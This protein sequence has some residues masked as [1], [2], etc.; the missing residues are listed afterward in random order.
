MILIFLSLV[1][2]EITKCSKYFSLLGKSYK[3]SDGNAKNKFYLLTF[4]VL[5]LK[6]DIFDICNFKNSCFNSSAI[7]VFVKN[8]SSLLNKYYKECCVLKTRCDKLF[9]PLICRC[10]TKRSN[11]VF[12]DKNFNEK[13]AKEPVWM[14]NQYHKGSNI[15]HFSLKMIPTGIIFDTSEKFE[16]PKNLKSIYW[17]DYK[18]KNFTPWELNIYNIAL[19][20]RQ[21][22]ITKNIFHH[23]K[24][25]YCF[26]SS[27]TSQNIQRFAYKPEQL[28]EFQKNAEQKFGIVN[29]VYKSKSRNKL[30]P[31]KAV[32]I[33]RSEG[34]GHRKIIGYEIIQKI[35]SRNNISLVQKE[36]SSFNS[37]LSQAKIFN[38]YGLIIAPQTAQLTNILFAQKKT[39]VLIIGSFFYEECYNNLANLCGLR[40][41]FSRGHASSGKNFDKPS[42][43]SSKRFFPKDCFKT[44]RQSLMFDTI[45]NQSIIENDLNTVLKLLK[46]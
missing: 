14:I 18:T 33:T 19:S 40:P 24:E 16:I 10:A 20:S 35:L 12:M 46:E 3:A 41:V 44:W 42:C 32:F 43:L 17:Q 29:T 21:I 22:N 2:F 9:N 28:N 13:F 26:E 34:N 5:L 39:V 1:V 31:K 25:R 15:Y 27:F 30:L 37:T 23:S 38:S 8:H 36:I 11:I 45:I 6:D 4:L 7:F